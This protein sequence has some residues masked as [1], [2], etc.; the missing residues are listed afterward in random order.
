MATKNP[1]YTIDTDKVEPA[2]DTI[3]RL[4]RFEGEVGIFEPEVAEYAVK[5]EYGTTNPDGTITPPRSFLRST[6]IESTKEITDHMA[7]RV[8]DIFF[9]RGAVSAPTFDKIQQVF[10][11]G[12]KWLEK[13]MKSKI[14]SNI[15]PPLSKRRLKEKKA[16]GSPH[17]NIALVDT[18]RMVNSITY[19]IIRKNPE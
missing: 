6:V 5:M 18:G 16:K 10:E 2:L 12:S 8:T 1:F 7:T 11:E 17:P 14:W 4:D 9:E 19:K 13:N 3:K 15:P